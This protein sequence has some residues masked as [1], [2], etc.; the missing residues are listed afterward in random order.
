MESDGF[1]GAG[2]SR[3]VFMCVAW[4]GMFARAISDLSGRHLAA[5]VV[6][7]R[8]RPAGAAAGRRSGKPGVLL[9]VHV[10]KRLL[11]GSQLPLAWPSSE[12]PRRLRILL[13]ADQL[14]WKLGVR[15]R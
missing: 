7:A 4:G 1:G 5:G 6:R 8:A 15:G 10:R 3:C 9:G 13:L 2:C 14:L 12:R 11:V